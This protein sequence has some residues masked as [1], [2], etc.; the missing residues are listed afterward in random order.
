MEICDNQFE[1]KDNGIFIE[2]EQYNLY[3]FY[4]LIVAK[5]NLGIPEVLG[6]LVVLK[7]HFQP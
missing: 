3:Q 2:P 1:T 7:G 6:Y 5:P 4:S